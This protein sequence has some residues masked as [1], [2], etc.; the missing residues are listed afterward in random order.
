MTTGDA[1]SAAP[2]ERRR[3]V[4]YIGL[5]SNVGDRIANLRSAVAALDACDGV[6]V[7]R[8]SSVYET[9]PVGPPQPDFY[10]AVV[11]IE[12]T[13]NPGALL[14]ACKAIEQGLGRIERER[15]G[16]REIDL[17]ILLF[18]DEVVDAP[19]LVVPHPQLQLRAFVVVPLRELDPSLAREVPTDGVR[20][21]LPSEALR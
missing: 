6:S 21:L 19:G 1:R 10:N 15:W 3:T 11:E 2:S 18:G 8:T 14:D 20:P 4:A 17:D 12:T 5:G 7:L 16:P 13:L 9:D